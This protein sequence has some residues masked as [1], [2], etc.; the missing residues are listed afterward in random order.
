MSIRKRKWGDGKEAWVID[1]FDG[2]GK[3]RLQTFNTQE[4]AELALKIVKRDADRDE[5]LTRLLR[6]YRENGGR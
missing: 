4:A 1:Y 5:D 3:R 2:A 6:L